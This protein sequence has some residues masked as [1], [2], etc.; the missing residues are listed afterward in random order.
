L[1]AYILHWIKETDRFVLLTMNKNHAK[2]ERYIQGIVL[3]SLFALLQ[4]SIL[5]LPY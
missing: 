5:C 1:N 3:K 2:L 4:L